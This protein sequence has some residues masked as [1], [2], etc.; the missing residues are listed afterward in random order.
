MGLYEINRERHFE[1]LENQRRFHEN[2]K[3]KEDRSLGRTPK[4]FDAVSRGTIVLDRQ[5]VP[6]KVADKGT[7]GELRRKYPECSIFEK[8]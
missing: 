8:S 6:W 2:K 3:I 7:V 5:E 4:P 1:W